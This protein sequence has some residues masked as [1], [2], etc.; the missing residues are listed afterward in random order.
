MLKRS[1][2]ELT[3]KGYVVFIGM[4]ITSLFNLHLT[5]Y[6]F[7]SFYLVEGILEFIKVIL[8]PQKTCAC[9]LLFTCVTMYN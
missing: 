8:Y 2:W 7:M 3:E 9:L 6:C 5:K 1:L 4:L